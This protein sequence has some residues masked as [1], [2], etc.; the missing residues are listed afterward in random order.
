MGGQPFLPLG[1]IPFLWNLRQGWD[2]SIP[3]S[4]RVAFMVKWGK[5]GIQYWSMWPW[6]KWLWNLKL[7]QKTLKWP[8]KSV[9]SLK[10]TKAAE[11]LSLASFPGHP[12]WLGG[13]EDKPRPSPKRGELALRIS[14]QPLRPQGTSP[15][16]PK[17]SRGKLSSLAPHPGLH[18]RIGVRARI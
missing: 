9:F 4:I 2:G 11:R 15:S 17:T 16:L 18:R 12:K 5:V 6:F 3:L 10:S 7:F 14:G 1:L 8:V 13:G